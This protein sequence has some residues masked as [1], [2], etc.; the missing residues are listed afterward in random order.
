VARAKRNAQAEEKILAIIKRE[1]E[2]SF[3]RRHF[4]WQ[5]RRQYAKGNYKENL[6]HG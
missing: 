2:R 3:W 6:A 4:I 1:K 5:N